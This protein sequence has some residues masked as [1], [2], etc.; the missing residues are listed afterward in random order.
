MLVFLVFA[1]PIPYPQFIKRLGTPFKKYLTTDEAE[2]IV[3][4]ADTKTD[5]GDEPVK[6]PKPAPEDI[7]I[8]SG[9]SSTPLIFTLSA[10]ELVAWIAYGVNN[11]YGI[12]SS[13]GRVTVSTFQPFA[14][15][16]LWL[17]SA[18]RILH[19]HP[20]PTPPY[21]LFLLYTIQLIKAS[22]DVAAPVYFHYVGGLALPKWA[23]VASSLDIVLV[24]LLLLAVLRMPMGIPSRRVVEYRQV[25]ETRCFHD[26]VRC[27]NGVRRAGNASPT[28]TIRRFG[29]GCKCFNTMQFLFLIRT[30]FVLLD[31]GC[32]HARDQGGPGRGR[33]TRSQLLF[34]LESTPSAVQ[35]SSVRRQA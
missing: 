7:A 22:V 3:F 12:L 5:L 24:T 17:Y 14:Q 28:R 20:I 21:D 13:D 30:Q 19:H 33:R 10:I 15:A 34:P 9:P 6:P 32:D 35:R 11:V 18:A 29:A 4:Q 27:T 26:R 8:A 31:D 25:C 16:G 2:A 1:I 23:V